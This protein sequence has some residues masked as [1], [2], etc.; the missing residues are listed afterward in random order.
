MLPI[1]GII[2]TFILILISLVW[3][4]ATSEVGSGY[5]GAA[6]DD[7][8]AS[9]YQKAVL[10]EYRH[11][12]PPKRRIPYSEFCYPQKFKIQPQQKLIGDFM[13]PQGKLHEDSLL[14]IHKIGAGKTCLSI[15]VGMQWRRRGKPLYVMPASLIPG[16]RA[17]LRSPCAGNDY[18]TAA[19]RERLKSLDPG[20]A[21]YKSI[22]AESDARIDR[23][24]SV[25]SYNKFSAA[26]HAGSYKKVAAPI[27]IVDELQNI[28]SP[29]GKYYS[30]VKKWVEHF[31]PAP[32]VLMSATPL[33]DSEEE[34]D[35]IATL[36][37]LKSSGDKTV[38]T[39]DDIRTLFAG[40]VSYYE[41]APASTFP[42]VFIKV[43]K[44]KM[45]QHQAKWY[46]ATVEAEMKKSGDIK[47]KE[48]SDSFY[49]KSRQRSNIVYPKGL[50]GNAGLES[51]TDRMIRESLDTY[52]AKYAAVIKKLL[53][54]HGPEGLSFIYT[55]FTGAGGIAALKKCLNAV[56][57]RD[58]SI[59]GPG[60]RRYVVWSGDETLREKDNIRAV[61]NSAANDDGSQIQVVIGS[62]AIKEGV[63]LLRIRNVHIL[64]SY[65]NHSRLEQ[66][67]GRAVRYCS[68]KSL[69]ARDRSVTIYI[70][71]AIAGEA[72]KE[73][74][75]ME[76]IDLYMLDIADKKRDAIT[77][78]MEAFADVAVDKLVHYP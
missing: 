53:R 43:K 38:I 3:R 11:L 45:S 27:L 36:M 63:S 70:Y 33:F 77:P 40:R 62:P 75:P 30:A 28:N 8:N 48:I 15:Q 68:H 51:L 39:P 34:I 20:S 26:V 37:R 76:S 35:S 25:M 6:L 55:G 57:F 31:D 61:F 65:W 60:R 13:R 52:S 78:Y 49:I 16:F 71:A 42:E 4:L 32:I 69:P 59:D 7:T 64:E 29:G 73:P 2:I 14:V 72:S 50:T 22:I 12:K 56:G 44:C 18:I 19:E 54:S 9:W 10:K 67:F 47:L 23:D 41:G 5:Y 24:F 58:Y 17:E 74:S 66:I 1:I 46:R 21:E